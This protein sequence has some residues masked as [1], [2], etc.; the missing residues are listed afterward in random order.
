M[1]M[2]IVVFSAY[3]LVALVCMLATFSEG[4]LRKLPW[5]RQRATGLLLSFL[6]PVLPFILIATL[7][8][9]RRGKQDHRDNQHGRHVL[10]R[11]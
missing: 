6:W 9:E 1:D 8:V 10:H 5:D 11:R 7:F 3:F 4:R 2:L